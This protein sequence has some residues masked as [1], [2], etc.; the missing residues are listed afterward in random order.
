MRAGR[1]HDDQI[2][3]FLQCFCNVALQMLAWCFGW[4]GIAGPGI[5]AECCKRI[6]DGATAFK[7]DEYV[8]F[9]AACVTGGRSEWIDRLHGKKECQRTKRAGQELLK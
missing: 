5:V 2:P 6:S 4:F 7:G 8:H 1:V 9:F 3:G